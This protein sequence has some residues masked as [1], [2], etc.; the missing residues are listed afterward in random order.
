MTKRGFTL[1]EV[2]AVVVIIGILS[3]IALPQYRKVVE[4]GRFTKAEVMAKALHDSCQRLV[5][6]WGVETYTAL[7]VAVRKISRLDIGAQNLLPTGFVFKDEDNFISGA[8]FEYVLKGNCLVNIKKVE[9]RYA[10]VTLDYN[11]QEF[12]NCSDAGSGA[13]DIY[14]VD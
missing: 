11:G 3:S 14:G 4:K 1:T 5:A 8:G 9:G 7:P 10:G 6:E 2:L 12:Y 13:C